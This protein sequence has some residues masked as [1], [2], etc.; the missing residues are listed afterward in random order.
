MNVPSFT[1]A[2]LIE[3]GR[4]LPGEWSALGGDVDVFM[5]SITRTSDGLTLGLRKNMYGNDGKTHIFYCRK[6]DKDGETH[7]L[8]EKDAGGRISDPSINVSNTKSPSEVAKDIARRLL[9]EAE[10]VHG[11]VL[12]ANKESE[13]FQFDKTALINKLAEVCET[14]PDVDYQTKLLNGKVKPYAGVEEFKQHGYGQFS[15]NSGDSVH[16]ELHSM[17]SRTAIL[18]A[19]ALRHIFTSP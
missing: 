3:I 7:T 9:P 1:H 17:S 12:T 6:P 8:W 14:E 2:F 4:N 19:D 18:V 5:H 16:L 10:R 11:L 13:Q 15:V